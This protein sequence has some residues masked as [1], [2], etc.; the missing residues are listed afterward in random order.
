[1]E[2]LIKQM[3]VKQLVEL[4]NECADDFG[5]R[6]PYVM[7]NDDE[8]RWDEIQ[9]C[10]DAYRIATAVSNGRFSTTDRYLIVIDDAPEIFTFSDKETLFQFLSPDQIA[11]LCKENGIELSVEFKRL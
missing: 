10:M 4:L 5:S 11:D 3:N 8:D 9:E 2:E 7:D 1:M 6:F